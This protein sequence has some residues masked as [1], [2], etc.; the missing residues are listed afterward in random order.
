MSRYKIRLE[1]MREIT[2]FANVASNFNDR[3]VVTDNS[4]SYVVNAKSILGLM[5]S[6][7]WGDIY[8]VSES[9]HYTA[10]RDFII[11]EDSMENLI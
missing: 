1:T 2:K 5:Y 10:F 6:V 3:I 9:D 8:L 7:E 11:E 4:G